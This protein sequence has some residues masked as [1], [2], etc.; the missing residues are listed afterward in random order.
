MSVWVL[1]F[2]IAQKNMLVGEVA[3]LLPTRCESVC[4]GLVSYPGYIP[5]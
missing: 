4:D 3:T 5:T 2:P 1:Q